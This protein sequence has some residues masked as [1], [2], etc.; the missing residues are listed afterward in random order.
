M[1]I[2]N[3]LVSG[4]GSDQANLLT[5][6]HFGAET[7]PKIALEV[8]FWGQNHRSKAIPVFHGISFSPSDSLPV[9]SP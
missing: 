8:Q 6:H 5:Y 9:P 4:S 7:P 1:N 3:L 2:D